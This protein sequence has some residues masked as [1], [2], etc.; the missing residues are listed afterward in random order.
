MAVLTLLLV[1]QHPWPFIS[2]PGF[3]PII[4]STMPMFNAPEGLPPLPPSTWAGGW[5]GGPV[6][7]IPIPGS[8][9]VRR[10]LPV[11]GW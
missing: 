1:A 6:C 9:G 8:V 3:S 11:R 5:C 10:L 2:V 4:C 7:Q